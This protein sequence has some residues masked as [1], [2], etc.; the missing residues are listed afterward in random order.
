[1]EWL[2]YH[3]LYYFWT[4][5]REGSVSAAGRKL[6]LSQ[7]TVSGQV[8]ALEEALD[9]QL[10]YRR[11]S[12]LILTETGSHVYRYASEIFELGRELQQSLAG[13][14]ERHGTR[15]VVG[16]ADALPKLIVQRL[17]QPALRSDAALRLTCYEN[18]HE[19]LLSQLALYELDVV[20]T[21]VPIE[22]YS[23]VRGFS[24]LLGECGVSLFA[25]ESLARRLRD[26]FPRS[27]DGADVILPIERTNLRRA[28]E[29]WFEAQ[30]IRPRVRAE[31]QDA[32]LLMTLGEAGEGFFA[33]PTWI[34]QDVVRRHQVSVIARVRD[35]RERFYALTL[36]RRITHPAVR[37]LTEDGGSR[38]F[39]TRPPPSP[40]RDAPRRPDTP[41]K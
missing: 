21:D 17:L 34:E 19:R 1:V 13:R 30:Q 32:A 14:A 41:R 38:L 40:E 8:R 7:P 23:S 18:Q 39:P 24:H 10:F 25:R 31:A 20:L 5:V 16:V 11:G 12:R 35:V 27:L 28:L 15:L 33:A 29:R 9:V 22:A 3:H 26:H 6:R 4:V 2:N 37:A 36:D